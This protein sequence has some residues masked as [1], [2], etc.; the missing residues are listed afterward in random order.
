[1]KHKFIYNDLNDL[2]NDRELVTNPLVFKKILDV[3]GEVF[4]G[5][6]LF[7]W[8]DSSN[9]EDKFDPMVYKG[10][11]ISDDKDKHWYI[12]VKDDKKIKRLS[13]SDEFKD[14]SVLDIIGEKEYK[15]MQEQ[16]PEWF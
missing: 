4:S 3:Y 1:M 8:T 14:Y 12:E 16:H 15:T 2:V 7:L 5:M 10:K 11:F 13:E 9:D 6:E